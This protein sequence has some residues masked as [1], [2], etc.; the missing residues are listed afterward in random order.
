MRAAIWSNMGL[1][2]FWGK[3]GE[4]TGGNC[5]ILGIRPRPFR[6]V[7]AVS[8]ELLYHFSLT[9]AFASLICINFNIH[10]FSS[11]IFIPNMHI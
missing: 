7:S 2:G 8:R 3:S 11:L 5:A 10:A 4:A 9:Y 1:P 6:A